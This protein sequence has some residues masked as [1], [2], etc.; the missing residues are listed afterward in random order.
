MKNRIVL[1]V[2][3]FIGIGGITSCKNDQP[4][5]ALKA[6]EVGTAGDQLLDENLDY[7]VAKYQLPALAAMSVKEGSL[8]EKGQSGE[9][10][11]GSDNLVEAGDKWHIGSITKSMTA[12]L[13]AILVEKGKLTWQTTVGEII[14]GDFIADYNDVTI[15]ELLSHTGGVSGED[16]LYDPADDRPVTEIRLEWALEA[17][18]VPL[19]ERGT[20][21]YSNNSFVIAGAMLEQ[22]MDDTWENLMNTYLFG[23]LEMNSSGFGAPE[24]N[25]PWGHKELGTGWISQ[26]PTSPTADNPAAIGP[27]GTVHTTLDDMEKYINFHLG[28]TNLV[29]VE[30]LNLLHTEVNNSGYAL[31]WNVNENG[32]FHSGSNGRWFAQLF[33]SADKKLALFSATNSSDIAGEKS[34]PAVQTALGLLG[35]RYQNSL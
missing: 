31:G 23:P 13:T 21:E 6:P 16:L 17:L 27:A 35:Q 9:R 5:P 15:Y 1:S 11:A 33:I 30:N 22:I 8:L 28:N 29:T 14:K 24:G 12:S 26:N 20:H 4:K 25:E 18:N 7:M 2:I 32:I 3:I 19:G 10:V 34:T